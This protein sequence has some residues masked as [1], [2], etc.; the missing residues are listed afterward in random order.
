V[1]ADQVRVL[2]VIVRG[3]RWLLSAQRSGR[4]T[5]DRRFF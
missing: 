1:I 4:P 2:R 5:G 3:V